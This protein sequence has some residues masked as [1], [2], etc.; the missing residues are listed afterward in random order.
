MPKGST[1]IDIA[2]AILHDA[3]VSLDEGLVEC[4]EAISVVLCHAK[5]ETDRLKTLASVALEAAGDPAKVSASQLKQLQELPPIDCSSWLRSLRRELRLRGGQRLSSG[6]GDL[7]QRVAECAGA[8]RNQV[9]G[10]DAGCAMTSGWLAPAGTV[11]WGHS[12]S[13]N[14]V[15]NVS[16]LLATVS[17]PDVLCT[18]TGPGPARIG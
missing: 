7:P 5:G 10:V 12:R 17:Y 9:C 13:S 15:W 4:V 6:P 14:C 3:K 2:A 18:D 16:D 1:I 11:L 8:L